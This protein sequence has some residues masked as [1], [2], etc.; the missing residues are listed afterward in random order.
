M[1]ALSNARQ[2]GEEFQKYKDRLVAVARGLRRYFQGQVVHVSVEIV[3][4]PAKGIDP[5]ADRLA[6]Q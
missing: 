6:E 2:P 1:N 5:D 3:H 4:L